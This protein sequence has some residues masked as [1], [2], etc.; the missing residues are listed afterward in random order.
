MERSSFGRWLCLAIPMVLTACR[1]PS[2]GPD[3]E[4]SLTA[5]R[6]PSGTG[7]GQAERM[8]HCP[9]VVP[10]ATTVVRE[11]PDAVE[12]RITASGDAANEIRTRANDLSSAADEKRGKHLASGAGGGRFGR[13]PIVM[14]NTKLEVKEV[15][16]G[17]T[18]IVRPADPAELGWLRRESESRSAQLAAPKPFGPGRM[19]TCPNA[20]P[21]AETRITDAP[22]GVEMTVTEP[23]PEGTRLVRERAKELAARGAPTDERCPAFVPNAMIFVAESPDGVTLTLKAKNPRD[24]PRLR[25]SVRARGEAYAPP[26]VR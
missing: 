22:H 10:G 2:K 23:S 20:V 3:S 18:V 7:A 5:G 4:A 26:L 19:T 15:P 25:E 8:P 16:G 11:V 12:L 1:A 9:S 24:V 13:C 6:L 17:V 21:N 14:R